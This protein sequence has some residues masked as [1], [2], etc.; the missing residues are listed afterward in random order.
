MNSSKEFNFINN[1]Q[2]RDKDLFFGPLQ[3]EDKFIQIEPGWTMANIAVHC[4]FFTSLS[5][6]RK[7]GYGNNIPHGF[8]DK[9]IGKLK[10]RVT[11][12]NF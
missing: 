4:G 7:N 1:I 9:R 5:Q 2:E 10:I 6:A 3:P 11:I 12:L 8:F